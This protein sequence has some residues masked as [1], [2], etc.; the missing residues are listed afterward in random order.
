MGTQLPLRGTA[1]PPTFRP[2]SIVANDWMDQDATWYDTKVGL[3]PGDIVL[4]WAQPPKKEHSP[5]F[6]A[7]GYCGQTV[8]HLSYC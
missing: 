7:H 4:D 5:H 6:S 8:A 2:M 3:G 1:A